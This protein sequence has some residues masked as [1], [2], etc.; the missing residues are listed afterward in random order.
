MAFR[1]LLP[2]R[3]VTG[4]LASTAMWA[5]LIF[6]PPSVAAGTLP[7][8]TC[9][10][11]VAAPLLIRWNDNNLYLPVLGGTAENFALWSFIGG[12]TSVPENEQWRV[13]S[14]LD[15]SS[16]QLSAGSTASPPRM[17]IPFVDDILMH[18]WKAR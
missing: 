2:R 16:V 7:V 1:Y 10:V 13:V 6:V 3:R 12:A 14:P 15:Q 11:P 5:G 18:P 17:C 8:L 4:L 9:G